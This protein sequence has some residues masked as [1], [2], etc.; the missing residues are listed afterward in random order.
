MSLVIDDIDSRVFIKLVERNPILWDKTHEYYK[1]K[2]ATFK[3]WYDIAMKIIPTFDEM[4]EAQ[5]KHVG[6]C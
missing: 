5:Q 1:N 6:K 3:G 2:T 4:N